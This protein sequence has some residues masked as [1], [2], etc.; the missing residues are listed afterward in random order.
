MQ[1]AGSA[2]HSGHDQN[3]V[4]GV[5]SEQ[6]STKTTLTHPPLQTI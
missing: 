1:I 4:Q 3:L 5:P 2:F 6:Q